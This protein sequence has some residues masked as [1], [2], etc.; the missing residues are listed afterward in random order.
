MKEFINAVIVELFAG[1]ELR[2]AGRPVVL[3]LLHALEPAAEALVDSILANLAAKGI[4]PPKA[5]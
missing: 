2:F 5:A 3:L 4:T 1:L